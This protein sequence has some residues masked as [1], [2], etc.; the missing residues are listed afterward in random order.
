MK[1][2]TQDMETEFLDELIPLLPEE[3][4]IIYQSPLG[5]REKRDYSGSKKELV[6]LLSDES[7]QPVDFKN[8]LVF[9]NYIPSKPA[10][11]ERPIP[12]PFASGFK[13]DLTEHLSFNDRKYMMAFAGFVGDMRRQQAVNAMSTI[14]KQLNRVYIRPSE[15]FSKG[16]TRQEYSE[17]MCNTML[18]ICPPGGSHESFRMTEALKAG[19]IPVLLNKKDRQWYDPDFKTSFWLQSWDELSGLASWLINTDP[20]ILKER[21]KACREF[22]KTHLSPEAVAGY[23]TRE[24]YKDQTK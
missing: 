1:E 10:A 9:R 3:P 11:N 19:C 2:K 15:G 23:I 14:G 12:L 5:H 17:V 16:L 6:I 13:S 18:A 8:C 22:Y 21:S 7:H 20:M 24:W 4:I